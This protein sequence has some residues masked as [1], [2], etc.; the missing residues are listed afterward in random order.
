MEIHIKDSIFIFMSPD[1][2]ERIYSEPAYQRLYGDKSAEVEADDFRREVERMIKR[3]KG[4][5]GEQALR[6][7]AA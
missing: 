4:E 7:N 1:V 2:P 5:E 3:V 6:V